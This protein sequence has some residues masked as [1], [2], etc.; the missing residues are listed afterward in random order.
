MSLPSSSPSLLRGVIG[1]ALSE[2]NTLIYCCWLSIYFFIFFACAVYNS[3]CLLV[4][5]WS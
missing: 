1:D 5:F 2:Y 4:S 3:R